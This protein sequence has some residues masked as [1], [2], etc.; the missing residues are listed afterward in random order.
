MSHC[1][2]LVYAPIAPDTMGLSPP[3]GLLYLASALRS[4]SIPVRLF[5]LRY[6]ENSWKTVV[7][8]VSTSEKCLVGFYCDSENLYRVLHLS[9]QLLRRFS[10]V[11]TVLG[12]PHV[13]HEWEPYVRDRRI[14]VR[15]EGEYSILLLAKHILEG[16]KDIR[17]IPGIVYRYEGQIRK[18]PPFLGPYRNVDDIPY[19][20][21]SLL[22]ASGYYIPA[23]ITSRGCMYGCFF[24]SEGS[25][26][27]LYRPRSADN[28][29]GELIHLKEH[30]RGELR[31]LAF[32]DDTFTASPDRVHE[33]CDVI[34]RVFPDK[35]CFRFFCEGRV[36]VL[37]G[38]PD[39]L[40]R[41]KEAGLVRLQIG[42]ESGN[43][44][45]L[46]RINKRTR[47]E[48]VQAV[49]ADCAN[50]GIPSVFGNFICGL[51]GQTKEDI[52]ADMIFA[53][54]LADL[55]P[56][57]IELG[58]SILV[59]HLGTEFRINAQQWGLE[60]LDENFVTGRMAE[61]CFS[62]TSH[63]SKLDV[64]GLRNRFRD[65]IGDYILAKASPLL[66]PQKLKELVV[67]A[68]ESSARSYVVKRF[69]QFLHFGRVYVMRG[70]PDYRFLFEVST[71]AMP[72]CAPVSVMDNSV[73][74]RDG[75]YL[76]NR[77]SPFEFELTASQMEYYHYFV[78]KLSFDE[79]A[80]H[81]ATR[82]GIPV[83][84]AQKECEEVYLEC[85][86]CMAAVTLV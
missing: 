83:S 74:P 82:K 62:E 2:L 40:M 52:E 29:E 12:G 43:Q 28:V 86:D 72:T 20:D 1:V 24:C 25:G 69:C 34:D 14:V 80:Q 50:T 47:V 78:G 37:A 21:Y 46:D 71:D 26:D 7:Q 15:G 55:A 65:E 4:K 11:T 8:A 9:D 85:E 23:V 64:E 73:E 49:V 44:D 48:Q 35:S 77:G 76:I 27:R 58:V 68:A 13:T 63:L 17:R 42:I 32:N 53:K 19:P 56:D 59:P 33:M 18:N 81:M 30:Y 39:L 6:E 16:E 38:R 66:S 51:P 67:L 5:D 41:L 31:Y 3:L 36:D 54:R 79:I 45:M 22:P 75:A 60:L 57:R 61:T 10:Q 84:Q 70:H